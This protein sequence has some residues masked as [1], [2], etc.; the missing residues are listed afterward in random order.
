MTNKIKD[1]SFDWSSL[2]I[3]VVMTYS[4]FLYLPRYSLVLV[5]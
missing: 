2:F 3:I 4:L 1:Q 5:T